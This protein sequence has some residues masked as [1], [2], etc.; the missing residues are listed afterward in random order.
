M[1]C[2]PWVLKQW[3]VVELRPMYILSK[4]HGNLK[5]NKKD[6]KDVIFQLPI[7][8][9]YEDIEILFNKKIEPE[10]LAIPLEKKRGFKALIVKLA[11]FF[12]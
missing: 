1:A 7:R 4:R 9:S 10:I 5:N 3:N 8:I 2:I 11:V 12:P 6:K